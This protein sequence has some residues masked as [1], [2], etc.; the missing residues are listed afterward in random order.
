[1]DSKIL[2]RRQFRHVTILQDYRQNE[3]HIICRYLHEEALRREIHEGL[4][5]IENWNSANSFIFYGRGG[6]IASNRQE[7]QELALLA[8]H[9]LQIAM[10]YINTLMIQQVLTDETWW[11]RMTPD[12]L[13][14][15]TPLI[16]AHVTPYG[17]FT[18]DMQERLPL[19]AA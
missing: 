13:R 12:D 15:L 2:G 6:E 19:E 7:D 11:A 18:L 3:F 1:M 9:L 17:T 10:V 5:V 4:Q 8:L 14:G 16:Y